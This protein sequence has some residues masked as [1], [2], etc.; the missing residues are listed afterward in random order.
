MSGS[1]ETVE[2]RVEAPTETVEE[3]AEA[4]RSSFGDRLNTLCGSF[5][6]AICIAPLLALGA[7]V[8]LGYNERNAACSDRAIAQG[9]E[10]VEMVGCDGAKGSDGQLVMFTCD[11]S[12]DGLT[13]LRVSSGLQSE[14]WSNVSFQGTGLKVMVEMLQCVERQEKKT[15]TDGDV[16]VELTTYSYSQEWRSSYVDSFV[17]AEPPPGCDNPSSAKLLLQTSETYASSVVAGKYSLSSTYVRK[18]PLSTP[19]K[20]ASAPQNWSASGSTYLTDRWLVN[21]TTGVGRV[22]ARA[23]GND[24]SKPQVTVLG[25]H[26]KG[27]VRKWIAPDSWLCSSFT[28][29]DLRPGTLSKDQLFSTLEA[30]ADAVTLALRIVGFL[31][32]WFAFS[33]VFL[34]LKVAADCIPFVGR[35]IGTQIE[36]IACCISCLPACA[37]SAGV[38]G[39]VW[40]FMRPLVG[41]PLLVFFVLVIGGYFAFKYYNQRKEDDAETPAVNDVAPTEEPASV[42]Q[43]QAPA[44]EP[45]SVPQQQSEAEAKDENELDLEAATDASAAAPAGG[46]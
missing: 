22:R 5:F 26:T 11:L 9:K 28:L 25:E 17:F 39:V 36:R 4:P 44:E 42:P 45:A 19:L 7:C 10:Q 1:A 8:L 15:E 2:E 21:S 13:P 43:Q 33:R 14:G 18:V 30:E 32:I 29:A 23:F 12:R 34:P 16:S 31:L 6:L 41:I 38:I 24:W 20:F 46:A 40:V 35:W 27:A 3:R 37:C